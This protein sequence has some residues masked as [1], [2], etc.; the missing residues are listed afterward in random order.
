MKRTTWILGT[1]AALAAALGAMSGAA[2]A[3]AGSSRKG[4]AALAAIEARSGSSVKGQAEFLVSS[5]KVTMTVTLTGLTPGSHA[6]HLHEKG[7]CSDP[8]AKSAGAH[9]NPTNAQHG[10]WGE[11]S[12]HRGDIGNLVANA[13]GEATLTFATDLWTIGGDA[14]TDV[15]G[16]SVVI[17]DK[18]DDFQTQPTGNAAGRIG[19]GVIRTR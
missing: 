10:R 6:I 3:Q 4:E 2:G 19:C 9:W 5:G 15:I 17:H 16:R 14:G 18:A 7:D 1:V 11:G 13:A 8:E 12:F